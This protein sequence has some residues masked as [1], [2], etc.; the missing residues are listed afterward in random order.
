MNYSRLG[1]IGCGQMAYALLKGIINNPELRFDSILANDINPARSSL[2]AQEFKANPCS[3]E[4]LAQN[5]DIILL[6]VKPNQIARVL[7]G[8]KVSK[9]GQ[10]FISIAAGIKIAQIE[11]LLPDSC[12]V[13]RV[14]PNT[15]ALVGEGMSVIAPGKNVNKQQTDLVKKI[16]ESIGKA[17]LMEEEYLDAVTAVSGSGPAYIFLIIEAMIDAGIK[18]G[19]SADIA[20]ELVLQTVK[21]SVALLESGEEHPAVLR[22]KVCSPAGTTIAAV[23]E[24]EAKGLRN[25]IYCAVEAAWKRSIELAA[26]K[27]IG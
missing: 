8:L 2:F 27:D 23:K 16:M 24:L 3:A 1:V 26:H 7:T 25:A 13:I 5:S 19:L 18:I 11:S 22:Q 20:Q 10:L 21:G 9:P 15:P 12:A 6:A 17:R 14:M 4:E